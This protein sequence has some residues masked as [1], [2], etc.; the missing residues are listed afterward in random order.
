MGI[1]LNY[2]Q[3]I[4]ERGDIETAKAM[5]IE[6]SER[7]NAEAQWCLATQLMTG[8]FVASEQNTELAMCL[9]QQSANQG[10][11]Y[12][13]YCLGLIYQYGIG[14]PKNED[15]ANHYFALA[16]KGNPLL[17][18]N[19]EEEL[20]QMLNVLYEIDPGVQFHLGFLISFC[21][22]KRRRKSASEKKK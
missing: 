11:P 20:A 16:A 9:F 22:P 10:N 6:A 4:L 3:E 15:S 19:S 17:A 21:F 13:Q 18:T 14:A 7:G 2:L 1:A 8:F 12:A 5:L